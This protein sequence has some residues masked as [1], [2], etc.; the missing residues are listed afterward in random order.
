MFF[1]IVLSLGVLGLSVVIMQKAV[2]VFNIR[3]LTIP[4]FFYLTYLFFIFLPSISVALEQQPPYRDAYFFAVASVLLTVP[5]GICAANYFLR[6][7]R[8]EIKEFYGRPIEEIYPSSHFRVVFALFLVGAMA[9]VLLYLN[10][11]RRVPLFEIIK[12]PGAY[13]ESYEAREE[14]FKLL[15]TPLVYLFFLLRVLIFPFL[16]ILALGHYLRTRQ[17]TWLIFFVASLVAGTF[18]AALSIA[19][20]PVVVMFFT[21]LL[22][23]Y[24]YRQGHIS[25]TFTFILLGLMLAF[26][27]FVIL[28][29]TADMNV[30][31]LDAL[32]TIA[33][34]AFY[35][36]AESIYYYFEIFPERVGYLYGKS[37]GKLSWIMGWEYFNVPNF[38]HLYRFPQGLISGSANAGFV[39]GLNADFGIAGVVL[40]G[41]FTGILMEVTQVYLLRKRKTILIMSLYSFLIF[42]F[43][44][45]NF[46]ALPVVLLSNGLILALILPWMFSASERFLKRATQ[47]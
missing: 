17:Q 8:K 26:P 28:M 43:F 7:R 12:N 31:F 34:R 39:A 40:G 46:A 16:T 21:I 22:F 47:P 2:S 13:L 27:L 30:G 35:D 45:L 42:A 19:K 4:A 9:I 23:I 15:D 10:E 37:I 41:F 32:R 6:F 24:I 1:S 38:V 36:P 5:L 20:W 44:L 3:Q 33:V 18:Y 14:S 25:K 29:I 11:V